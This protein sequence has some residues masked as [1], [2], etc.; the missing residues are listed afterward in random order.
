MSRDLA[1]NLAVAAWLSVSVIA[2]AN[3]SNNPSPG[4]STGSGGS[5]IDIMTGVGSASGN[6]GGGKGGRGGTGNADAAV[7]GPGFDDPYLWFAGSAV[8]A[9][10]KRQTLSSTDSGPRYV[11]VPT[12]SVTSFHDLTFDREGNLWALPISGNQII[13]LPA[14][15]LTSGAPPSPNLVVTSAAMNGPGSISFDP[16]GN[17]WVMN[18]AGAGVSVANIVRFDDPRASSGTV[19]LTASATLAPGTTADDKLRF[20]QG[21]AIAFDASGNLWFAGVSNLLRFDNPGALHGNVSPAP[22]AVLSTREALS[23]L[24]F[25]ASGALWVTGAGNGYFVAR[26]AN[27]GS[28]TGTRELMPAAKLRLPAGTASFAGGMAFDADGALWIAMSNQLLK[29][30]NPGAL[31]GDVTPTPDV[32]LGV[33]GVPDLTSKLVIR[34]KPAGLPIF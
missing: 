9:F 16:A 15:Q 31:T 20:S 19:T 13:R 6:G 29:V 1:L 27:P 17:L 21:T 14:S 30:G 33:G 26:I 8:N 32:Q 2:C 18:F 22:S 10:T 11:F 28:V 34:P 12:F 5:T 7:D 23:S 4:I 24:V 25:D 3:T